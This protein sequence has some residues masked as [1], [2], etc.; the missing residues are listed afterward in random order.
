M[1]FEGLQQLMRDNGIV[2]CGGAGFPSYAK[3][4][5]DVDT[6]IINCAECEPLLRL[7]RQLIEVRAEEIVQT[8]E[9][10]AKIIGA[11]REVE[12]RK[13]EI[14][15]LEKEVDRLFKEKYHEVY[16]YFDD[17]GNEFFYDDD[18][19]PYFYGPDGKIQYYKDLTK[20]SNAKRK[21]FNDNGGNEGAAFIEDFVEEPRAVENPEVAEEEEKLNFAVEE[22]LAN[23]EPKEEP[24]EEPKEVKEN[25]L[26]EEEL[27]DL[28]QL[29]DEKPVEEAEE[30]QE[31]NL[32][33]KHEEE[34]AVQENEEQQ[35]EPKQEDEAKSIFELAEEQMSDLDREIENQNKILEEQ[36]K[37]LQAQINEAE[38]VANEKVEEKPVEKPKAKKQPAKKAPSKK[39]PAKKP[40]S[41][42]VEKKEEKKVEKPVA[43]K[44]VEKPAPVEKPKKNKN[45]KK[46]VFNVKK[47]QTGDGI[48]N[49]DLSGFD[50]LKNKKSGK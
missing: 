42:K 20:I 28:K 38:K 27:D 10:V 1:D 15:A 16:R 26:S 45:T 44:P 35:V 48:T 18:G 49:I 47:V 2:G 39:V 6:L 17:D 22:N 5:K 33:E 46:Y 37:N 12:S 31:E 50:N 32:E 25:S 29:L 4:N 43:E 23:E 41:K 34:P 3:L 30:K 24:T 36:Y 21:P 8:A 9:F 14:A 19:K 11:K 40:A 7:H 13:L